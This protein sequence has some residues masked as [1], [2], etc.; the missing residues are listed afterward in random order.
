MLDPPAGVRRSVV[1]MT[2][3]DVTPTQL[4]STIRTFLDA[5]AARELSLHI[6]DGLVEASTSAG[7]QPPKV[8]RK[9]PRPYVAPQPGLFDSKD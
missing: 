7:P 2:T 3:T 4:P 6:G 1:A 8:E 9:A 5:H